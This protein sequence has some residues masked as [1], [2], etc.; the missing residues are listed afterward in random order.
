MFLGPDSILRHRGV[1]VKNNMLG[2][3]DLSDRETRSRASIGIEVIPSSHPP[4]V[5]RMMSTVYFDE[6]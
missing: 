4:S 1:W 3:Y 5:I 6:E 2:S